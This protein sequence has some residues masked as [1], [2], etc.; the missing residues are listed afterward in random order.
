VRRLF[1][2]AARKELVPVTV[3]Q[4]LAT[5]PGLAKGRT[6]ARET[7][8]IL[9]VEKTTVEATLPFLPAV[10]ADMVRLQSLLGCRPTEVCLIRPGDVDTSGDVWVYTPAEHKTEHHGRMRRIFV[11]SRAQEI[12][13]PYLR[14][15]AEMHCFLPDAKRTDRGTFT[16]DSY[17]RAVARAVDKAN[18][19]NVKVLTEALGRAP[20]EN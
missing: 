14:R 11:G 17:N 7:A 19:S 6:N 4:A 10:F 2:W 8:S 5:V 18:V 16:K 13:F 9:P 15:P 12:L 3:Y 20:T 1:K